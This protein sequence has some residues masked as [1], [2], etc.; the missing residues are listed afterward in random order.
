MLLKEGRTKQAI[1][2]LERD[3]SALRGSPH[4]YVEDLCTKID[5]LREAKQMDTARETLEN[6]LRFAHEHSDVLLEEHIMEIEK[7]KKIAVFD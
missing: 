6:L 5:L 3:D 4:D 1:H 2:L 7:R